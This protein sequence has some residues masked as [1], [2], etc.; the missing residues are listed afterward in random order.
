MKAFR[1][2]TRHGM[3]KRALLA[4]AILACSAWELPFHAECPQLGVTRSQRCIEYQSRC[5]HSMNTKRQ[6]SPHCYD[7]PRMIRT[8]CRFATACISTSRDVSFAPKLPGGRPPVVPFCL[9]SDET[10]NPGLATYAA[11]AR[12]ART[13]RLSRRNATCVR[14]DLAMGNPIFHPHP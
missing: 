11:S 12:H 4:R 8:L 5:H 10:A 2:Q 13:H 1:R 7:G 9:N 6:I 14:H 3:T